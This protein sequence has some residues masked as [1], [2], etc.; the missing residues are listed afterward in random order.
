YRRKR[1]SVTLLTYHFVWIPARRRKVLVGPG[2][3]R[4]EA[5]LRE[6]AQRIECEILYMAIQPD[7]VHIFIADDQGA[8][9]RGASRC[10]RL[11]LPD[12]RAVGLEQSVVATFT[13]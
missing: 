5:L 3:P 2:A 7:H 6:A 12:L 1:T 8:D 9:L 4:L 11:P 10:L 13:E